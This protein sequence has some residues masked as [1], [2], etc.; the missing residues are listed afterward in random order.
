MK[1]LHIGPKNYPP[2][3]GGVEKVVYDLVHNMPND[4]E[5]HVL[6]EWPQDVY[7]P[8]VRTLPRGLWR[9]FR[10]VRRYVGQQGIDVIH[11]HK[12][13]FIPLALLLQLTGSRCTLTLHGCAWRLR[14]W[15]IFV[16]GAFFVFDCLACILLKRVVFVSQCD[17]DLFARLFP[18]RQLSCIPNGIN[19]LSAADRPRFDAMVYLG[20]LSPEK[21]VLKLIRT[22]A[23]TGVELDLYGPFD[24][25]DKRFRQ[26]VMRELESTTCV[27]WKG[28]VSFKD[29]G[30]LLSQY[31]TFVNPSLSEGLPVS[32]LEAASCGLY[33]VLSDI[34]QH[35]QLRMPQCSYVSPYE[36]RLP[37]LAFRG[38]GDENRRH[39]LECFS[40]GRMI[41]AYI[42][43]YR[44]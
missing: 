13:T 28:P 31:R 18:W 44:S 12:E 10:E 38:R 23:Q 9:R 2:D 32:V 4:V 25:R 26:Q 35:R 15:P 3:H 39:V 1:V 34:P 36:L 16:R 41:R 40:I 20:R 27:R 43:V 6:I 11:L 7:E 30:R 29:I 21:N 19:A 8:N 42:G 24:P 33:L 17:R 5:S 22:A 14:R 37:E